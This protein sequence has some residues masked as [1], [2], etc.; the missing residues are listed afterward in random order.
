MFREFYIALA[1]GI[2]VLS[3][4][5]IGRS[6]DRISKTRATLPSVLELIQAA[7][8]S[9]GSGQYS[10]ARYLRPRPLRT[11]QIIWITTS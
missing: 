6:R 3:R 10:N 11:S 4:Q 7:E 9:V 2:D 8:W 1:L 5:H